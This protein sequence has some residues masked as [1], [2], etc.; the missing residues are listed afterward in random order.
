MAIEVG[1][2]KAICCRCATAYGKR[3]GNFPVSYAAMYKGS[4]YLPVCKNCVETMYLDYLQQCNGDAKQAVRQMC[5]KLDLY[6][7]EQIF[8]TVE[9]KATTRTVMTNYMTRINSI[10]YAGKCYDDT[11]LSEGAMWRFDNAN[12]SS[13]SVGNEPNADVRGLSSNDDGV[14]RE[15]DDEL[16]IDEVPEELIAYWGRGY[17][18]GMYLELEQRLQYYRSQMDNYDQNDMATETLL[19][20]IA[21]MEIDINR[22]RAA[23]AAVDKMVNSL[24]S[25]LSSLK[26][27]QRKESQTAMDE[28]EPFGVLVKIVERKHP[29][30]KW[31]DENYLVKY[32]TVWLFGHLCKMLGIRNSYCKMYE[33]E[34]ERLR[35]KHPEYDDEDDDTLLDGVF[36]DVSLGFGAYDNF[37]DEARDESVNDDDGS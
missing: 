11:L 24:N 32:I 5:R 15:T 17:S 27:P 26:K 13:S 28:N 23:G 20:Q 34:I 35:V 19:R 9:L 30:R 33:D 2:E 25:M 6:W 16:T 7:N 22:A 21:M 4:G 29:V 8:D 3:R 37:D 10:K 31:A 18:P 1:T 36:G 12:N 14:A